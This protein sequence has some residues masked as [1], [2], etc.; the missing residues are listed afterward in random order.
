MYNFYQIFSDLPLEN[1]TDIFGFLPRPQL[2]ELVP[3]INDRQFIKPIIFFLNKCGEVTL[4]KFRIW[5]GPVIIQL[6]RHHRELPLADVP[7]P[8]NTKNFT[9]ILIKFVF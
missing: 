3:H 6:D 2:V 9:K 4:G 7:M 1:W 5:K 8:M